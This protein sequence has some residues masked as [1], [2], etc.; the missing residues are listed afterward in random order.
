MSATRLREQRGPTGL[1]LFGPLANTDDTFVLWIG[2]GASLMLGIRPT[3]PNGMVVPIDDSPTCENLKQA[4]AFANSFADRV[5]KM[6]G[7]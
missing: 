2:P 1:T 7:V 5:R 3:E 4:R 6:S